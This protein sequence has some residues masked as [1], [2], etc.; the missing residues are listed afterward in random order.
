MKSD[1][2]Q[3]DSRARPPWEYPVA[4]FLYLLMTVYLT[5][6]L[7]LRFCSEVPGHPWLSTKI[8]L[9][10]FWWAREAALSPDWDLFRTH[11]LYFPDGLNTLTEMGN[12]LLP[13]LSVPFQL[14]LGLAGG[15]NATLLLMFA[16]TG[17]AAYALCRRFVESRPAAL[18]GGAA[19]VF[20]PYA[21]MKVFDG[22]FEIAVLF[23]IPVAF[24]Q[25]DRC[26]RRPSLGRGA[27]LGLLL[28]LA[29]MSSWYY[30]LFLGMSVALGLAAHVASRRRKPE[31]RT[32]LRRTCPAFAAAFAVFIVLTWPL[33]CRLAATER[34]RGL[35][36]VEE[37]QE[38]DLTTKAN[39]DVLELLGPWQRAPS[40][41]HMAAVADSGIPYPFAVFPGFLAFALAVCGLS[42]RGRLGSHFW[43]PAVFLWA[44]S[45]GPW[46]KIAGSTHILP[47][48]IRL[49]AYY[50]ASLWNGFAATTIHSYRAVVIPLLIVAVLAALGFERLTRL[51]KLSR[52]GQALLSMVA[53][54]AITHDALDGAAIPRNAP[55]TSTVMPSV[56]AELAA[57]SGEGAVMNIP[58]TE[59]DHLVG[60]YMLAQTVHR[61]PILTGRSYE[62]RLPGEWGSLLDGL[63]H[64]KRGEAPAARIIDPEACV[65]AIVERGVRFFVVHRHRL[66]EARAR[67]VEQALKQSCALLGSDESGDVA[68]YEAHMTNKSYAFSKISLRESRTSNIEHSPSNIE[69]LEDLSI[70]NF[71]VGCSK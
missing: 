65:A 59:V 64:Y 2:V 53:V 37:S 3:G 42:V 22:E 63:R 23:W 26:F 43:T 66:S 49:P 31:T 30:G 52:S 34:V 32:S 47:F 28:F 70:L 13:A 68:I 45:L 27:G 57:F 61:R 25:M 51:F 8:H 14:M 36:W 41:Q 67:E 71:D 29:T 5:W 56:Y 20:L 11:L 33:A 40:D 7:V 50:L 69:R 18:A 15:Y 58:V 55:R 21:W 9:W 10:Q 6:P 1:G 60:D 46:L 24:I 12:F 48:R 17:T 35:N 54:V 44:V 16:A 62:E 4:F 39:P 19:Y 38:W